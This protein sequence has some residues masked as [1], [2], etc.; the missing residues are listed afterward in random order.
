MT[1]FRIDDMTCGHCVG[2]ITRALQA[3]DPSMDIQVD[4]ATHRVE[5]GATAVPVARL[6]S[7][8]NDAGYTPV[9]IQTAVSA[10]NAAI[11]ARSGCCGG[12]GGR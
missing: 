1:T 8:I 3:L 4:L 2:S 12:C 10:E 9:E 7:A 11:S 5:I 6:A